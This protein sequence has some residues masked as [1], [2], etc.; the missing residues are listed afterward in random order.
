MNLLQLVKS[1]KQNDPDAFQELIDR[2]EPKIKQTVKSM[3][4]RYQEDV[5]Q[6]VKL[7]I[8]EAVSTYD[9]DRIPSLRDMLQ[10]S[11]EGR[12][13]LEKVENSAEQSFSSKKKGDNTSN[14]CGD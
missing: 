2:F 8:F 7:K 4:T 3:E 6:E 11:K 5:E 12:E 14:L 13:L 1:A 10:K 9:T